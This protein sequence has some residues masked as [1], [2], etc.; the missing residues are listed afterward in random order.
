[1]T[2]SRRRFLEVSA[3]GTAAA[4]VGLPKKSA[5]G[6]GPPR[7]R[8]LLVLVAEGGMRTTMAFNASSRIDLNPWGV[9]PNAGA[10][11]LGRVLMAAPSSVAY[12]APS[13]PGSPTVPDITQA[14]RQ[15]SILQG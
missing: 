5:R 1:M 10:M 7:I 3:I 2:L 15:M 6:D 12:A 9:I 8:H 14:V 13:W 11:R 4:L